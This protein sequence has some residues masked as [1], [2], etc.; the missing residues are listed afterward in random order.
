MI[1]KAPDLEIYIKDG[2]LILLM[3]SLLVQLIYLLFFQRRLSVYAPQEK[4]S[5][6][7]IP[8]S[9]II[10]ARNEAKNLTENLPAILEQDY[11]QFEVV[12]V[13]D[14][15]FDGSEEILKNFSQKYSR[16]KVVTVTEHPRFKTGKK[17]ALTM[18][19]KAAAHE[20][21]LFTDADCKPLSEHWI[22]QMVAG[23]STPATEIVLGYSPYEKKRGPLNALIRFETIKTA[24]NYFS[25]ALR[26][27]AYMGV[28]RNLAY[29]KSLFFASKGFA[30]HMHV[31]SGDDDL[32]VNENATPV[33]TSISIN[34]EAFM[35]SEPKKSFAAWVRQKKRHMGAGKLYKAEH[36]RMLTVEAV[37]A[38]LFYSSLILILCLGYNKELLLALGL[39]LVRWI[40]QL[41]VYH[42]PFK[43]FMGG[44]M[45]WYLPII[46]LVYYIY[47]VIFGLVG[48]FIKTTQ[49]K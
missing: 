49:W 44:D 40:V 18:G 19:I 38:I 36:K 24:I 42:K 6:E 12:V 16:L 41:I 39:F 17:F 21:L 11:P 43:R 5:G 25:A 22:T 1:F 10:S 4:A 35:L 32:F 37:S 14:C 45:L 30:S 31:L 7:D 48:T 29:K 15:S 8:V 47:L 34:R 3:V 46:D 27:K 33:N 9:V 13:N 23:F 28:G 20:H 2:L 26:G